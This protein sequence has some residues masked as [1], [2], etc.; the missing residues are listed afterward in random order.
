[1]EATKCRAPRQT[2]W[3]PGINSDI[4]STVR[5]CGA[6]QEMLPSQPKEPLLSDPLPSR[7]F[8]ETSADLFTHA[9]KDY[10]VYADRLSG[11]CCIAEYSREATSR[12]TIRLL[13]NIFKD[14]GVPVKLRTEEGPQFSIYIFRSFVEK[15]GINHFLSTPRFPRSYGHAE[16]FVK[17][18]KHL[19]MK[20]CTGRDDDDE[21]FDRGLMELRNT[22]RPDSRSPAQVLYGRP[23]RT[24][25]PAHRRA[26]APEWQASDEECDA[27]LSEE[28]ERVE[29]HY[30]R[31]SHV[32]PP[33]RIGTPV[34]IQDRDSCR[35]NKLGVV[36]GTG[37][38]R[39]YYIK[40]PSG[41]LHWRNC[42]F[43]R[44]CPETPAP[45][46]SESHSVTP[47]ADH[48]KVR[49]S[50][51]SSTQSRSTRERRRPDRLVL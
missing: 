17:K 5:G 18:A 51:P 21:A 33:L 31:S 20:V 10:L 22:P 15:W 29:C 13:R 26:F 36:V 37:K 30:N 27:K 7:P 49:I 16:A 39:D 19:I 12:T 23:L 44:L 8:E 28:R 9:G 14:V 11:W 25:V 3:W 34:R 45:S 47:A 42:R 6:C 38:H 40:V 32:L 43:L 2:V 50:F 24:A 4:T 35:W 41:R 48:R 46:P 1:M